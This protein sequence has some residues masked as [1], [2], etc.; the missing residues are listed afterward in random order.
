MGNALQ[1]TMEQHI[2]EILITIGMSAI[3]IA[4]SYVVSPIIASKLSLASTKFLEQPLDVNVT[5]KYV[6]ITLSTITVAASV[7]HILELVV[8][9]PAESLLMATSVIQDPNVLEMVFTDPFFYN[10]Y[11]VGEELLNQ[12]YVEPYILEIFED[13]VS[14]TDS[15]IQDYVAQL[16]QS[17]HKPMVR[18]AIKMYTGNPF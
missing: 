7:Y 14:S 15:D 16:L 9:I 2:K 11:L 8:H 17:A 10:Q 12:I 6:F 18:N 4:C 3:G 13:S 1:T 5:T